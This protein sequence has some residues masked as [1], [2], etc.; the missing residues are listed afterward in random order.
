MPVSIKTRVGCVQMNNHLIMHWRIRDIWSPTNL[1]ASCVTKLDDT[2]PRFTD[3]QWDSA[4][5]THGV[6]AMG[7]FLT[8][9]RESPRHP[10]KWVMTCLLSPNVVI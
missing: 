8:S 4:Q 10:Q 7:R 5:A 1:V 9:L 6:S 2:L 3:V